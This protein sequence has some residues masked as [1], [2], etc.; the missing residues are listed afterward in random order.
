MW[1][2]T[3]SDD[4]VSDSLSLTAKSCPSGVPGKHRALMASLTL[5][6]STR[7]SGN[8]LTLKIRYLPSVHWFFLGIKVYLVLCFQT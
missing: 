2:W 5:T 6:F 8:G 1:G 3:V 4:K 7:D